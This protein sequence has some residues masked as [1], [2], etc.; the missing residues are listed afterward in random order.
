MHAN[1]YTVATA[2]HICTASGFGA[3]ATHVMYLQHCVLFVYSSSLTD[4]PE[5]NGR[6]V[7]PLSQL[8]SILWPSFV[9][10]AMVHPVQGFHVAVTSEYLLSPVL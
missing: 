10:L 6:S 4:L 2:L 1:Q 3:D 7:T 8:L 9:H 5:R